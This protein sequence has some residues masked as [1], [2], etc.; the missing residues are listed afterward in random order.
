MLLKRR[1]NYS[2]YSDEDLLSLYKEKEAKAIVGEYYVRYGHLVLG[3]CMKYLKNQQDAEDVT[4]S[5]FEKLPSKLTNHTISYF[6]SWLY[7]VTKNECLMLL[8][9]KGRFF[10][11][12]TENVTEEID[13]E[14]P[15]EKEIELNRLESAVKALKT[16]QRKCI[17]LFY[18]EQKSYQEISELLQ[19]DLNKI[20]SAIQNGKRNL[21]IKL[22][23]NH[24][25]E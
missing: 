5:L 12:L 11:D 18:I 16:D 6:K 2:S 3:T 15:I 9:K 25:F 14:S 8:R 1:Q 20:K 22:E 13:H 23:G 21:K 19:M 24:E 4:M 17:E 7:M 10:A